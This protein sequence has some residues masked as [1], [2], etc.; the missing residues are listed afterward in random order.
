MNHN[1]RKLI[2]SWSNNTIAKKLEDYLIQGTQAEYIKTDPVP[3]NE[4]LDI[5]LFRA[6]MWKKRNA[7]VIGV[8]DL[9]K[10]L[11]MTS[12]TITVHRLNFPEESFILFTNLS[13]TL[14]FGILL[15]QKKESETVNP[16]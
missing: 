10:N 8:E 5:Y 1:F 9:L 3:H 12:E 13:E 2:A 6:K 15:A 14:L 4:I 11:S 7:V 16:Y